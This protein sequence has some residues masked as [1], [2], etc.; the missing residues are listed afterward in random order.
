MKAAKTFNNVSFVICDEYDYV[1]K[2][3]LETWYV[4]QVDKSLGIW[5]GPNVGAQSA[6]AFKNMAM[7]VRKLE[8]S[9]MAFVS[10]KNGVVPIRKVV[11]EVSEVE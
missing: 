3:Q 9:D 1:K 6:I 11:S 8:F 4:T 2:L 5:I 7:E 10:D